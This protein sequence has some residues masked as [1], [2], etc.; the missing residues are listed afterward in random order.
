SAAAPVPGRPH[1]NAWFGS[2]A[3]PRRTP[4]VFQHEAAECGVACLA[5]VLAYHGRWVPLEELREIAGVNRDGTKAP[6]L[7]KIAARYNVQGAGYTIKP[8][9]LAAAKLP[10]IVF[11][12]F[13]HFVVVEGRAGERVWIN[14]PAT[15]PRVI[16]EREFDEAFTG[17]LLTFAPT[18]DFQ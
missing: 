7:V 15:G 1:V 12:N 3:R 18:P 17:V 9:D 13:N 11:W 10:A 6:N 4:T 2:G 14:D 16:T 5:M 8:E